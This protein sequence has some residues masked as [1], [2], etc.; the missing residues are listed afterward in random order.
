[1]KNKKRG[2]ALISSVVLMMVVITFSLLMF[3]IIINSRATVKY[4]EVVTA[5]NIMVN[6]VCK[7]FV[8]DGDIDG[9][10][11]LY[12]QIYENPENSNIK[13]VVAKKQQTSANI[14]FLVVYDFEN[15][16][17]IAKQQQNF[18]LSVKNVDGQNYYFL[19]GDV[20]YE[21]V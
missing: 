18:E 2:A 15:N 19:P 14:Y 1:M 7:D 9:D 6:K 12:L 5:K 20:K 11:D 21:R 17:I 13:A 8:D 16:E 10:Y 4:N 3:T